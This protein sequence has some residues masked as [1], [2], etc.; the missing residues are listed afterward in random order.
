M[1]K[2]SNSV[3]LIDS[4]NKPSPSDERFLGNRIRALRR[5]LGMTL[6]DLAGE[7]GLSTGYVSQLERNLANPS[8][9]A[10]LR[11]A[12]AL[13]VSK[14]WFYGC[15]NGGRSE[16]EGIVVRKYSRLTVSH[17][18]GASQQLLTPSSNRKVEMICERLAP[19]AQSQ[20]LPGKG[21]QI[22]YL[23]CGSLE[24][25]I[26]KLKRIVNEADSFRLPDHL[27]YRY[28][29]PGEVDAVIIWGVTPPTFA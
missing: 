21:E 20:Q 29:N 24:L 7:C 17:H 19:G 9:E 12:I 28:S 6:S 2:R 26:G 27:P 8:D 15:M 18:D 4:Q 10:V 14:H 23:Q 13:G 11:V 25:W 1:A 16:E 3:A 5:R 22:G